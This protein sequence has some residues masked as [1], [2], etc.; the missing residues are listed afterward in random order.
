MAMAMWL[1]KTLS[2][3]WLRMEPNHSELKR[4]KN[5]LAG[6]VASLNSR[7]LIRAITL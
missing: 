5:G 4:Q 6:A 3:F 2:S 7:K 1:S